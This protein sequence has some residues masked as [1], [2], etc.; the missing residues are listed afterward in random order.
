MEYSG[1]QLKKMVFQCITHKNEGGIASESSIGTREKAPDIAC[2]KALH[3]VI[4]EK[5]FRIIPIGKSVFERR[6]KSD[7]GDQNDK[8]Q[9]KNDLSFFGHDMTR[10][11]IR[12]KF[13]RKKPLCA[14][15]NM[16]MS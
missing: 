2:G 6:V 15:R 11:P 10:F 12:I 5:Q 3:R 13:Y 7:P 4:L 1:I 9:L 16:T 14:M 8:T